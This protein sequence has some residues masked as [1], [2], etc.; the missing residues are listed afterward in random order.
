MP[1]PAT[2]AAR[3]SAHLGLNPGLRVCKVHRPRAPRHRMSAHLPP[4]HGVQQHGRTPCSAR[5]K[6]V[7]SCHFRRQPLTLPRH[8]GRMPRHHHYAPAGAPFITAPERDA[9]IV[10]LA[11]AGWSYRRIAKAVGFRSPGSVAHALDRIAEGRPGR[12][13]RA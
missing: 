9:M 2:G 10:K 3:R 12:D 7:K 6:V 4:Q 13:P 8:T 5:Q 11:S 1:G